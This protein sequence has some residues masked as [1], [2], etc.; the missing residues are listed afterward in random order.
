MGC[1]ATV[2]AAVRSEK[3]YMFLYVKLLLT[4]RLAGAF[5]F[6]DYVLVFTSLLQCL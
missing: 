3:F 2:I 5:V 4:V 6:G 1:I